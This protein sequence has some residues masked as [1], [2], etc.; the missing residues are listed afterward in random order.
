MDSIDSDSDN[1][2]IPDVLELGQ[3]PSSPLDTDG[4]GVIDALDLDSDN[5]GIGDLF[6][7]GVIAV[8]VQAGITIDSALIVDEQYDL[9]S[10]LSTPPGATPD[11]NANGWLDT[12]EEA[13]MPMAVASDADENSNGLIDRFEPADFDEDGLPDYR[14][15]LYTSPSPRDA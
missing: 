13:M 6:E 5:D 10:T 2:G 4:D 12:I 3:D 14:C 7:S 9:V 11:A 15:L 1:D 8:L